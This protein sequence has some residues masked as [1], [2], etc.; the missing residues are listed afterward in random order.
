M[1]VKR[2]PLRYLPISF[3]VPPKSFCG[4]A[5][6]PVDNDEKGH[7]D[8]ENVPEPQHDVQLLID[9]VERKDARGAARLM[10][11]SLPV[12][13]KLAHGHL[14]K[15]QVQRRGEVLSV[16]AVHSAVEVIAAERENLSFR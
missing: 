14:W 15:Y 9:Y 4:E 12:L 2:V 7:G 6:Y 1:E 10:L 5:D 11:A 16:P 3:N 8:D 13:P